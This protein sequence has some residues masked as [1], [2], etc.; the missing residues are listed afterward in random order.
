MKIQMDKNVDLV[1]H[2]GKILKSIEKLTDNNNEMGGLIG[3]VAHYSGSSHGSP[4]FFETI[5][6]PHH[7][8]GRF[9]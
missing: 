2:E 4:S 9:F 1:L 6:F 8:S 3:K 7:K 5:S